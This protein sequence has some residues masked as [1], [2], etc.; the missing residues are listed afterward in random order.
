MKAFRLMN[1]F[2]VWDKI[3]KRLFGRESEKKN[4]KKTNSV[5]SGTT[6]GLWLYSVPFYFIADGFNLPLKLDAA[7]KDR[8]AATGTFQRLM[9][10]MRDAATLSLLERLQRLPKGTIYIKDS[11]LDHKQSLSTTSI[12]DCQLLRQKVRQKNLSNQNKHF[13]FCC[14]QEKTW[15]KMQKWTI[16]VISSDCF[17]YW[18]FLTNFST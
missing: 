5:L 10:T 15:I 9:D 16:F 1:E 7:A 2:L 6:V 18:Y 11:E 3:S 12:M 13:C 4:R 14:L 8:M 17:D